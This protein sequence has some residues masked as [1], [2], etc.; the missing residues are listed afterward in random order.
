MLALLI[1]NTAASVLF[2]TGIVDVS[3]APGLY[4]VFPL[5]ATFYGAF[6]ICL[7]LD[8]EVARFDADAHTHHD[9][10]APEIHPH[11]VEHLHDHDHPESLAA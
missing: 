10:A 11:N 3:A 6:L 4:V 9:H 7:A 1:V 5:V 8:K 2:L